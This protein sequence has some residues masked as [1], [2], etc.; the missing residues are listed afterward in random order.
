[1]SEEKKDEKTQEEA[2]PKQ[3]EEQKTEAAPESEA[4]VE[5]AAQDE[6]TEEAPAKTELPNRNIQPGMIVR[7]HEI[8][9]DVNARGEEKTRVQ[10]FEGIVLGVK[11]SGLS[12]TMTV[13]KD[14]NGFMVEKIYP[15]ASP[16]IEKVEVV[17]QYRTRRAKLSHLR[18][19]FKRKMKEVK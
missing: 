2:A 18:D 6:K 9:I 5:E 1:M 15:L 10:V 16:N 8:I 12:R 17:K 13:R 7:V 3:A 19:T 4:P 14:S 11:G